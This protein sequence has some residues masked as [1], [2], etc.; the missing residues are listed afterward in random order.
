MKQKIPLS[1][2]VSAVCL[3]ILFLMAL[4]K[5]WLSPFDPLG[6]DFM[7][8]DAPSLENIFGTDSLGRDVFSRFVAGARISFIVGMSQR[9]FCG[10][11]GNLPGAHG[12]LLQAAAGHIH[13]FH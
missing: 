3:F 2:W 12:G 11:A 8:L 7:P 1:T 4:F 9:G 10:G 13:A 5:E 6:I